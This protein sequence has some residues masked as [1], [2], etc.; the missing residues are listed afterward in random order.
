MVGKEH[1]EI[2]PKSSVWRKNVLGVGP[3]QGE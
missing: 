3:R 2:K 1:N